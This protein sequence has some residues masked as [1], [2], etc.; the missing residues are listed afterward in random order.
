M[1]RVKTYRE[2]EREGESRKSLEYQDQ[3]RKKYCISTSL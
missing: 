2:R 3:K 1:G